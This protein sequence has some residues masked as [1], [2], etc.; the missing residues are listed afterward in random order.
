MSCALYQGLVEPA[1]VTLVLSNLVNMV[2]RNDNHIDTG[3]LGA[4]YIL[5]ALTDNNRFS[6]AYAMASQKTAPSW[7]AW[8][9]QGAT[10]LWEQWNGADSHNHIMYG[11][12]SAWFYKSIAGIA[13]DPLS[14]GFK[15]FLIRPHV[16]H[17]LTWAKATHQSMYGEIKTEWHHEGFKFTLDVT[18]PPNTTA[19]IYI[20]T[21]NLKRIT[22]TAK[23][24]A[25]AEGVRNATVEEGWSAIEVDSGTYSFACNLPI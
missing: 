21:M 4:K 18:V 20:P 24:A 22:E 7:G 2:K 13:P 3:I 14:P 23:P 10:T 1:H 19:T 16:A 25:T 5:T 6:S 15:H 11:D 17:G 9:D 12:I 8:L